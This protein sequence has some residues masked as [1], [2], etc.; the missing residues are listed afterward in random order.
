MAISLPVAASESWALVGDSHPI[1][2]LLGGLATSVGLPFLAVSATAPLL[3]RWFAESGSPTAQ[4][5]YSLY[6]ASNAGSLL[7]LLCYPT[8]VEPNLTLSAQ[9]WAWT[10]GYGLLVLLIVACGSAA[11]RHQP[12]PKQDANAGR[13]PPAGPVGWRPRARWVALALVP[14]SLMLGVTMALSTDLPPVPMLWVAPLALYLLSFILVFAKMPPWV[15]P[16][17]IWALPLAVVF[18]VYL[19]LGGKPLPF[20]WQLTV[21]L[22]TLFVVAMV[23]H[24]ELARERPPTRYLTEYY[25]WL[26]V[27]GVLGGFVNAVVAP[28]LFTTVA[29]FPLT[30]VAAAFLMPPLWT[31]PT[32]AMAQR[33]NIL[34]PAAF[35]VF[36]A[37]LIASERTANDPSA[38]GILAVACLALATRPMRFGLGVAAVFLMSFLVPSSTGSVLYQGRS[39]FGI[40]R[41]SEGTNRNVHWLIHGRI[42]HGAQAFSSDPKTHYAPFLYYDPAGPIGQVFLAHMEAKAKPTVGVVGLGAGSLAYYG[43]PGQEFCF[44]EIDP[45]VKQIAE[46][47]SYFTFLKDSD[48]ACRVVLGDARLTLAHEPDGHFG[49]LVIDAFSGDA[50]PVHLLTTE[51]I[52]LYLRK[53]AP[54]GL[55]AFHISNN[56][57]ELEPIIAAAARDLQ[58]VGL[59]RRDRKADI[60][61][62]EAKRGRTPAHWLLVA[63]DKSALR[64]VAND[65]RWKPLAGQPRDRAWTDNYSNIFGALRP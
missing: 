46:N 52:E 54:D 62:A 49:L 53:L 15:H 22:S 39:F 12:M 56:H 34:L 21:H 6:A 9:G 7:A 63:R 57:L 42:E 59:S 3:Q 2:W 8:L 23:C 43:Q 27:G 48:A 55:M 17:M 4:D 35:C 13:R 36:A 10:A 64:W 5:P 61:Q 32:T 38:R 33:L 51:A 16:T 18:Q 29:E 37:W 19:I 40:S 58:L 44:F 31:T 24:G 47:S 14:S 50:V 20:G 11:F 45:L 26:S 1:P 28:L 60:D 25:L 30:L 65:Q 41:V